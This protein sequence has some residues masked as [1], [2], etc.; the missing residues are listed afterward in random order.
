MQ[1]LHLP[2]FASLEH[3][4]KTRREIFLE[5]MDGLILWARL[6]ACIAPICPKG[7]GKRGDSRI[8]CR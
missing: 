5:R 6:E 1:C 3:Y 2:S 8:H 7:G 4:R